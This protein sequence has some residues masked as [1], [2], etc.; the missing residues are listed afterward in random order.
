MFATSR[1]RDIALSSR[2]LRSSW[3]LF[4]SML[5]KLVTLGGTVGRGAAATTSKGLMC[6]K[7]RSGKPVE[8]GEPSGNP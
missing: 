7:V 1:R 8:A 3:S 4:R 2:A 5:S 6:G